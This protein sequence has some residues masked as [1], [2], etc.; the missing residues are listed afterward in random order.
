MPCPVRAFS[1][2]TLPEAIRPV[3]R[4]DRSFAIA[5][6]QFVDSPS[7]LSC[8]RFF[9]KGLDERGLEQKEQTM[10][11]ISKADLYKKSNREVAGLKDEIRKGIGC[12]EQ[13]RRKGYNALE[14]IRKVQA[15][16]RIMR[17]N[18]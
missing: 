10:K 15:Q 8:G 18:L 11:L 5:P 16:R 14:D 9:M 6:V 13:Q 12:A 1:E 3:Q 7:V 4:T 2:W 17:P